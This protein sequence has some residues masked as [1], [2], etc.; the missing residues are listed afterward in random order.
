MSTLRA[1]LVQ[2]VLRWQDPAENRS[3]LQQLIESALDKE[4]QGADLVFLPETFT[5]GFLG[6]FDRE[7][8]TM[9][10]E[11]VEWMHELAQR[12][13]AAIGGSV[14]IGE[15]GARLNRFLFATPDGDLAHYDKRH[16][17][18]YGGEDKHYQAGKM[19]AIFDF[20]DWRINP[21]VCYDLRFPVWCRN[22][23]DYDL[24]VFVA[25]WPAKRM[26]AW[27]S[28]LRARAIENQACVIGI[29]RVG[30]DGKGLEYPGLSAAY[31]GL[32]NELAVLG[33]SEG[34]AMAT[35][36]LDALQELRS[37]L[38]F[39]DDADPFKLL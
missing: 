39:L 19:R 24:Q 25:N 3:H 14:I 31:D 1:L 7:P 29:N 6:D 33:D 4:P 16:L 5:T 20:R 18:G 32:G 17:F 34:T 15:K 28:L 10:G 38:P 8:E 27:A 23:G 2:P 13:D 35:L 11:T 12:F 37:N 9:D 21:Q 26:N 30:K 36:D 22:L